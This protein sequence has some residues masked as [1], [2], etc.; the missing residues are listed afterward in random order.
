MTVQTKGRKTGT[1]LSPLVVHFPARTAQGEGQV[2]ET[3]MGGIISLMRSPQGKTPPFYGPV[4]QGRE[5]GEARSEKMLN[6]GE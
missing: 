5:R 2:D 1:T 4:G 6:Q 3:K